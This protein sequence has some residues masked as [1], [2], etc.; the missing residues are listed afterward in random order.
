[1]CCLRSPLYSDQRRTTSSWHYVVILIAMARAEL[2]KCS[3]VMPNRMK[4]AFSVIMRGARITIWVATRIYLAWPSRR[5]KGAIDN[6]VQQSRFTRGNGSFYGRLYLLGVND[7][8]PVNPHAVSY[9]SHVE[10]C[11][12]I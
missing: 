8:F 9:G 2:S 5:L 10:G 12:E 7:P 1:M 6:Y 3:G 4:A 11:S